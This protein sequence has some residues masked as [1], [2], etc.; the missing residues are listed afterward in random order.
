MEITKEIVNQKQF[1]IT[2]SGTFTKEKKDIV[3]SE[4]FRS[5]V[6]NL[7]PVTQLKKWVGVFC[8]SLFSEVIIFSQDLLNGNTIIKERNVND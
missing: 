8:C 5:L 1:K 7:K 2:K 3:S 6:M 4:K